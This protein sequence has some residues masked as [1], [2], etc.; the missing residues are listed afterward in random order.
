MSNLNEA[1]LAEYIEK[2]SNGLYKVDFIKTSEDN[3]VPSVEYP[4]VVNKHFPK[5]SYG[6][7]DQET[8]SELCSYLNELT[9][10]Y[11][12]N[13]ELPELNNDMPLTHLCCNFG[14]KLG[15][16][17]AH[18]VKLQEAINHELV[19]ELTYLHKCNEVKL[20]PDI[21]KEEYDLSKAPTEKQINAYCEEKFLREFNNWK[22]AKAN[23]SLLNKQ[24]DLINDSISLEKYFLRVE[25]K[26]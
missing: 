9:R 3:K 19:C 20:N 22:I 6:C 11:L 10:D 15:D 4:A 13:N 5:E 17:N 25:L 23:T 2:Q 8:A 1:D 12:L 14:T 18:L 21:V 26:K 16:K 7:R 24:L